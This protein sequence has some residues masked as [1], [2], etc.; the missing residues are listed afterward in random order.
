[1]D[2]Y[3]YLLIVIIF[4][5][6]IC[7]NVKYFKRHYYKL[8]FDITTK[9]YYYTKKIKIKKMNEK[10]ILPKKI[11]KP[12]EAKIND[13][14]INVKN[15]RKLKDIQNKLSWNYSVGILNLNCNLNVGAIY[16]T[17]CLLGMKKYIIF[18]KK[19]YHPKSQVGLDYIDIDYVDTF[20]N[21]RD[22]NK[23]YTIEDFDINMFLKYIDENNILPILI[24]QGGKNI[25]NI[26]F[27]NYQQMNKHALFIFGNETHGTPSILI[28]YAKQEGWPL[29]SIP[30]WGCAHSFNVSQSANIIMWKYYQDNI[31]NMEIKYID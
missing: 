18:G 13:F 17:G 5:L 31:K 14:Y 11:K 29:L 8:F 10:N 2:I 12:I 24:E 4:L 3:H 20:K 16:R 1:M 25:I 27:K 7:N 19:I 9:L 26:N 22:R 23:K 15:Y 21:I 30:Q 28:K 6:I